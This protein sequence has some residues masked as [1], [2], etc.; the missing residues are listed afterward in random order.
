[1]GI[2]P[3]P[4]FFAVA[5]V[6]TCGC[7]QAHAVSRSEATG[8]PRR[9]V[10]DAARSDATDAAR[11]EPADA[12]DAVP[13]EPEASAPVEP[14]P[15]WTATTTLAHPPVDLP[16]GVAGVVAHLPAGFD[17]TE[18]IHL[19]LFLH[20][21]DQ[22]VARLA[23]SGDVVCIPGWRSR[24]GWELAARHDDAAT[25][26]AFVA[27][28]FLLWGGGSPGKFADRGYFR[29]FVEELLSDTLAPG[30]GGPRT[31]DDVADI[32]IVAHSAGHMPL[33]AILDRQDLD[34]KVKNVVLLDAL[35]DGRVGT[36]VRWLERG[37]ASGGHRKLVAIYGEWGRNPATGHAIASLMEA[38]AQGSAVVDPTGSLQDAIRT[39]QVTVAKWNVNHARMAVLTM[40]KV[41]EGLDLPARSTYPLRTPHG[42]PPAARELVLGTHISGKLE[43]GDATLDSGALFD[44]YAID[45]DAGQS[46][47]LNLHGGWSK[48]DPGCNLDVF[49]E[50]LEDGRSLAQDD[51]SGGGFDAKLLWTAPDKGQYVVRVSTSGSGRKRGSYILSAE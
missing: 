47:D 39:H 28:Q 16:K 14:K 25:N 38:R 7:T 49:L 30:F 50:V 40:S 37:I 10:A 34:D 2:T 8:V 42:D 33:A 43:D 46:L 41:L 22:C 18:P 20:G 45:L 24:K 48:T 31:L 32:T 13:I 27:P 17:A 29:S 26:T 23:L 12:A 3:Y 51:D 15:A 4:V 21:A 19:V 44:D 5:V 11:S 36:Y 35:Y 9:E 1:M 6:T